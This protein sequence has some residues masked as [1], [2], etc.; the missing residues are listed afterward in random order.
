MLLGE[1]VKPIFS[2]QEIPRLFH[3]ARLNT[4]LLALGTMSL[5]LARLVS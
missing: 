3:Q 2:P 5:A 1:N 4:I